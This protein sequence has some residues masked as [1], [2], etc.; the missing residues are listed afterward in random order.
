MTA[1]RH[2]SR[3]KV[4]LA[5]WKPS[6]RWYHPSI[7]R[8]VIATSRLIMTRLIH[9][10]IEGRERFDAAQERGPRGLLTYSNHVSLF[11]DPL[12]VANVVSGPYSRVRWVGADAI[13]FFGSRFKAGSSP[14]AAP[15]R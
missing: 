7:G 13:N 11:D 6:P 2:V 4:A 9:L 12:L 14:P 10:T 5:R 3:E 15:C 1:S 8:V